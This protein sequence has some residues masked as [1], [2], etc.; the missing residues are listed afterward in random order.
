M[1]TYIKFTIET[2]TKDH[3][4]MPNELHAR[5]IVYQGS[6]SVTQAG[7]TQVLN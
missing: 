3:H 5:H 6:L 4:R 1:Q 2:G 7:Q